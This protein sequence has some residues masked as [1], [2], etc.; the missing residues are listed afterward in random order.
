M[1]SRYFA[2]ASEGNNCHFLEKPGEL[3]GNERGHEWLRGNGGK[4][5]THFARSLNLNTGGKLKTD[6]VIKDNFYVVL[7]P[8]LN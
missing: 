8:I 7:K 2:Y 1:E 4:N 3:G 5:G 6:C